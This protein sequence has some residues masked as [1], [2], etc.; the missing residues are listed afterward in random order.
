MY[1]EW[2]YFQDGFEE[3]AGDGVKHENSMDTYKKTADAN[4]DNVVVTQI[5]PYYP[6]KANPAFEKDDSSTEISKL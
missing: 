1:N 5:E 6:G 2:L 4:H 3:K